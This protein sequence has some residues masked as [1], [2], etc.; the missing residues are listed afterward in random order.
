MNKKLVKFTI[1]LFFFNIILF[2]C[3]QQL[4]VSEDLVAQVNDSY[5]MINQLNYLVPSNLEPELTLALKKNLISDWV[6]DEVL[7]QAAVNEGISLEE[8]EKFLLENYRKSFFIQKFL[9]TKLNR[10]YRISQK[11]IEDYYKEH[12]KEFVHKEDAVRIVHLLMEQRDNAIFNEIRESK[13]L[14]DII[15]KYY[16]DDKSTMER[17]NGDLGY[18]PV[19]NLPDNFQSVIQRMKTGAISRPI[20]S[21]QGYHFIQLLDRQTKG[22]QKDL[23]IVQD[24]IKLRLKKERRETE[25]ARLLK[26][27]KDE[28]QIQTSRSTSRGAPTG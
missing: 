5:L 28:A 14:T 20:S 16:F 9:S 26:D 11:E 27:L 22:N 12:T 21:D 6:D 3:E 10:N 8:K 25:L 17:P 23:E 18:L 19:S 15:K 7:Y 4:E 24:E 1:S 13:N 2:S